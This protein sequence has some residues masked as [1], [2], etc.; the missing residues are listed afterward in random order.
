MKTRKNIKMTR[1]YIKRNKNRLKK[2]KK[3]K[4][5]K[6]INERNVKKYEKKINFLINII[7][8][9]ALILISKSENFDKFQKLKIQEI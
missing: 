9:Y 8:N 4:K 5:I 2:K 6:G 7:I 1:K 3:K